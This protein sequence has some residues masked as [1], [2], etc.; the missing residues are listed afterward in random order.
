MEADVVELQH[1]HG[2]AVKVAVVVTLVVAGDHDQG[3]GRSGSVRQAVH[4][5]LQGGV[6]VRHP[7][8]ILLV[9]PV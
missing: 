4:R 1:G 6:G 7:R 2:V 5:V 9:D 3:L 8:P